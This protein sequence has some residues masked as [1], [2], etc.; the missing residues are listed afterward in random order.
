MILDTRLRELKWLKTGCCDGVEGRGWWVREEEGGDIIGLC[1][2]ESSHLRFLIDDDHICFS[3]SDLAY[4]VAHG[5]A[6]I[7][8]H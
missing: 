3:R 7:N 6:V 4:I 8:L 2:H 1:Q 5:S